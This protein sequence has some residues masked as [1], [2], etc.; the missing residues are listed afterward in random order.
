MPAQTEE[1]D[2]TGTVGDRAVQSPPVSELV[3][4]ASEQLSRLIREEVALAAL[5]TRG[6]A[7]QA[8]FGAGLTG[9]AAV[10]A[11]GGIGALIA[12][13][14][15]ALALALPAWAAA[16]I[17]AGALLFVAALLG[18]AGWAAVR[19]AAPPLPQQAVADIRTDVAVIKDRSQR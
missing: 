2:M 18:L 4:T 13:A 6:K 15:L 8:G 19:K 3:S 7:R 9:A 11:L 14:I 12:A 17:I 1:S 10:S 16:L 5:E